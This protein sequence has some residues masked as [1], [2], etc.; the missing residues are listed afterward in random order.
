MN[1]Y[2]HKNRTNNSNNDIFR[3]M[4]M[5]KATTVPAWKRNA[6]A[7]LSFL[8]AMVAVLTSATARRIC[9][10]IS[11]TVILLAFVAVIAAVEG[12]AIGI[13]T[14]ILISLPLLALEYLCLRKQ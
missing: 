3:D 14:A 2:Y 10:A 6:D 8:A 7:L 12:G 5:G 13:G 1:A 9:R 11:F 4:L